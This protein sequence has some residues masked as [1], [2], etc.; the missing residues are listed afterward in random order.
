MAPFINKV[1]LIINND[2]GQDHSFFGLI[3][4]VEIMFDFFFQLIFIFEDVFE[5]I[6]LFDGVFLFDDLK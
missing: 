2:W 1:K 4:V 6:V 5:A 3:Q